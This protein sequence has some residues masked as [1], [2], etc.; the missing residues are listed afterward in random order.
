MLLRKRLAPFLYLNHQILNADIPLLQL[1]LGQVGAL[2]GLGKRRGELD[3][4]EE[5]LHAV[6]A[7]S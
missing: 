1:I 7:K 2:L 5:A 4:V 6:L 3:L